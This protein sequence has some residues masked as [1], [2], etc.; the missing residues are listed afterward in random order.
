MMTKAQARAVLGISAHATKAQIEATL[1]QLKFRFREARL[2]GDEE[3]QRLLSE[4]KQIIRHTIASKCVHC[5][6]PVSRGAQLCGLCERKSRQKRLASPAEEQEHKANPHARISVAP[7]G[8]ILALHGYYTNEV[9]DVVKRWKDRAP[10]W[11]IERI[12]ADVGTALA[13]TTGSVDVHVEHA[14]LLPLAFELGTALVKA[15]SQDTLDGWLLRLPIHIATNG[16]W[17]SSTQIA[18][19]IVQAGGKL[20]TKAAIE[21]ALQRLRLVTP[22][23]LAKDFRSVKDKNPL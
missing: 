7:A 13:H 17:P 19:L 14:Y 20:Y 3:L 12:A 15:R 4:A 16:A 9:Q 6:Q 5:G 2:A 1:A 10:E 22:R 8:G 21:K 23:E 18:E 11:L